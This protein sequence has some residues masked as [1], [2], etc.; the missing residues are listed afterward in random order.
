MVWPS[1]YSETMPAKTAKTAKT[2]ATRPASRAGRRGGILIGTQGWSYP[3]WEGL[4]YP[5]GAPKEEHLA[6]YAKLFPVVEIDSSYYGTPRAQ[7]VTRWAELVPPG[8]LFSA[9]VPG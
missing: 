1:A 3:Q 9:K 2:A 5:A 7:T 4:V 8:F 6:H